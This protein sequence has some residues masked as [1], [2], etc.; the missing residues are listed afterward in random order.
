[1][2]EIGQVPPGHHCVDLWNH[3]NTEPVKDRGKYM[4]PVSMSSFDPAWLNTSREGSPGCV[5]IFPEYLAV[6]L[7]H[8]SLLFKASAGDKIVITGSNPTYHSK[9]FK[10]SAI[11]NKIPCRS[12]FPV[13]ADK[14]VVQLFSKEELID[15]QVLLLQSN[16][17]ILIS[18]IKK[19]LV[20]VRVPDEMVEIPG[21][22]FRFHTQRE[23]GSQEPFIAFPDFSDTTVIAMDKFLMDKYPIT[24]HQWKIFMKL[25]KYL[26]VDSTNYLHHWKYGEIPE[27]QGEFPVVYISTEDARAY[28]QWAGKRLPTEQEWQYAAQGASSFGVEDMIGNVWQITNDVYRIGSYYYTIIRGGSYYHPASSSWYITGGPVPANHPEM[29]LLVSEGMD[30]SATVGFRCVKDVP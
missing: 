27:G 19:T 3:Q 7:V 18:T 28:A 5:A 6:S 1:L 22:K 8:D 15:E 12:Y 16:K 9:S 29:L 25:S 2:F 4:I 17:P 20:A 14:V 24:N 26:P 21:G 30:R 13:S 11:G 23:P 10:F